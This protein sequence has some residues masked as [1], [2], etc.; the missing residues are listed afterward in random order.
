M[1]NFKW[2][3]EGYLASVISPTFEHVQDIN[4]PAPSGTAAFDQ[5]PREPARSQRG[6]QKSAIIQAS[7]GVIWGNIG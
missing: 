6:I 1:M 2:G 5:P 4:N 3:R 7:F